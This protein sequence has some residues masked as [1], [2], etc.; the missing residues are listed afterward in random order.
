[1]SEVYICIAITVVSTRFTAQFQNS[2]KPL[3][4]GRKWGGDGEG[5]Q[6]SMEMS[7]LLFLMFSASIVHGLCPPNCSCSGYYVTCQ[8]R[9]LGQIPDFPKDTQNIYLQFNE[10]SKIE[11]YTFV[12]LPNLQYLYINKNKIRSLESNTFINMTNLYQL[13]LRGNNISHIEEHAFGNLPS[14]SALDLTSNPLNCDCNIFSFWSWLIE[15]ASIGI[16]SK[17]SNG[18]LVTSLQPVKKCNS[19]N[20]QCF[21][22]GTY[23]TREDRFVVCECIG[24]WTGE[25]CQD[26]QCL[27]YDCGFGDCFIEPINGTAQCL[28]GQIYVNYCPGKLC[29]VNFKSKIYLVFIEQNTFF[30]EIVG[31]EDNKDKNIEM[32]ETESLGDMEKPTAED[33]LTEDKSE[34]TIQQLYQEFLA[35]K[36]YNAQ[37]TAEFDRNIKQS[38]A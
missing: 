10:I 21:N 1:M 34:M 19:N 32:A 25:F 14:L 30:S 26:S 7:V 5:K 17:C 6:T 20:F 28:C 24:H 36:K 2:A 29:S 35:D 4:G 31:I 3:F 12:N 23:V 37:R 22:G 11:P 13:H 27:S 9:L 16:S 38:E 18:S 15:R 33:T 8:S